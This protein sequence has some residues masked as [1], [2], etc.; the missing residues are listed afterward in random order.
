[1]R[2][3]QAAAAA[4]LTGRADVSGV[5]GAELHK[6]LAHVTAAVRRLCCACYNMQGRRSGA[7]FARFNPQLTRQ[8]HVLLR[9]VLAM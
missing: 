5:D 4:A 8:R 7:V 3:R 9:I 6:R 2:Q 1:M